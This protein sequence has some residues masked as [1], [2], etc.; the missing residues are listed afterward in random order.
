MFLPKHA[1]LPKFGENNPSASHF[2]HTSI[3]FLSDY[4]VL[5]GIIRDLIIAC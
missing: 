1:W 3:I 2:L 5:N 4:L